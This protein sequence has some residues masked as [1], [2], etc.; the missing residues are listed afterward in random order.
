MKERNVFLW[1][2]CDVCRQAPGDEP[3]AEG[4]PE[5]GE[6]G[7]AGPPFLLLCQEAGGKGASW[8]SGE[9][10]W[11]GIQYSRYRYK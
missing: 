10:I 4:C 2:L 11:P 3:P 9:N 6:G 5:Q 1:Q 8:I 7:P